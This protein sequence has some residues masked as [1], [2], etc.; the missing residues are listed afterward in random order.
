VGC[1]LRGHSEHLNCSWDQFEIVHDVEI[2]IG[3]DDPSRFDAT[4]LRG[5]RT[6][7]TPSVGTK[8]SHLKSRKDVNKV[9]DPVVLFDDDRMPAP[10][11]YSAV[12]IAYRVHQTYPLIPCDAAC[13]PGKKCMQADNPLLKTLGNLCNE[14]PCVACDEKQRIHIHLANHR[15][16]SQPGSGLV[17]GKQLPQKAVCCS[18]SVS[19]FKAIF[20]AMAAEATTING[21]GQR[22][23]VLPDQTRTYT[24]HDVRYAH[25]MRA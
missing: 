20:P 15:G 9:R 23:M 12:L 18:I 22:V 11:K 2:P 24:W 3:P 25:E 4:P 6:T 7:F 16:M 17:T 19:G 5:T 14:I 10:L 21:S 1:G 13:Y 8:T